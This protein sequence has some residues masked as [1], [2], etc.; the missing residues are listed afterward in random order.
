VLGSCRVSGRRPKVAEDEFAERRGLRERFIRAVY[1][2]RDT[3]GMVRHDAIMERMGLNPDRWGPDYGRYADIAQYF[4]GLG[5]IGRIS[6]GYG[7][8][9]ITAD[10]IRYVEGD[11]EGDLEQQ[12]A[13]SVT[14]FNVGNAYGSIFGTQEHAAMNNVSF[15]FR[16]VEAELDRAEEEVEQR[17]GRDAGELK[18]LIAEVRALHESGEPLES[19]SLAKYLGVIRRNAWIASPIAGT[20]LSI[21]VDA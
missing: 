5:F 19:G 2:L 3:G 16:T 8:V 4:D 1:D 11:V 21:V 18:E 20:L 12:G 10:G 14:F 15:D 17:G 6:D 13:S 9:A 7:I